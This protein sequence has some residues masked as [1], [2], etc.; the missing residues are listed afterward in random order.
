[1]NRGLVIIAIAAALLAGACQKQQ[2]PSPDVWAVVNGKEIRR[3]EVEK[4][5]KGRIT[6]G[7]TPSD[8]EALTT[9][10]GILDEL[11]LNEILMERAR[12][13]GVEASDGEVED[14]FT[15]LKSPYTED[16][17]LRQLSQRGMSVD[18]AKRE[19]RRQL[20]VQKLIN[21][22][23]VSKISITDQD[24]SAY[25]EANREEFNVTEARYRLAQIVVTPVRDTQLRNLQSNDATTPNDAQRKAAM[26][27]ERLNAGAD[28]VQL[29]MDYS[30]D[31][32]SASTGGDMGFVP[33]S[34]FNQA[35]PELKRAVLGMR[36]GDVTSVNS[37]GAHRIIK[38]VSREL[39]GQ[40]KLEDPAV[41]ETI[42]NGLRNRKEQLLR[43][44]YM[45]VARN[46]SDVMN[47]LARQVLEAQG[48]LPSAAQSPAGAT[49][50]APSGSTGSGHATPAGSGDAAPATPPP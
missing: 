29:A 50:A 8:E 12:T 25:Y 40:R 37:G 31:P 27:M 43:A 7:L 41:K 13:L 32:S 44:A 17:F 48:R 4:Y 23:V 47:Y 22:E 20:S 38:L 33:E 21:R 46:E 24:I 5:F 19:L 34:A 26:L 39:P 36:P 45:T 15:E 30:E 9:K 14:K 11:I 3:D 18:D 6:P 2:A 16:E 1:M 49:P 28:F 35:P 42:R 10:L